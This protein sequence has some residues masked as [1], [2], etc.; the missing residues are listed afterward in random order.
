MAEVMKADFTYPHEG[1]RIR[2]MQNPEV[3]LITLVVVAAKLLYS[4]DGVER[5][6]RSDR[7]FRCLKPDWAAWREA[8]EDKARRKS[9]THLEQ[10]QEYKV[11][12]ND[13]LT[14][15][16]TKLDDYMDW[17]EKMWTGGDTEPGSMFYLFRRIS[18]LC[19]SGTIFPAST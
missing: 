6:P 8:I 4:L 13:A 10:G 15:D 11:T 1:K 7:D 19:I 12:P 17:F 16:N 5:A 3:L 2:S 14:M 9:T 18:F